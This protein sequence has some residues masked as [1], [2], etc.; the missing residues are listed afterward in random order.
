MIYQCPNCGSEV[1]CRWWNSKVHLK[2]PKCQQKIFKSLEKN[3]RVLGGI[4]GFVTSF[5]TFMLI[6]CLPFGIRENI[7]IFVIVES[8]LAIVFYRMEQK[9][10][11]AYIVQ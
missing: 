8:I 10:V 11:K 7:I 5:T 6:T 9:L 3:L 2:C 1:L 4:T